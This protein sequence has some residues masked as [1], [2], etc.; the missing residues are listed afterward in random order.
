MLARY[1]NAPLLLLLWQVAPV[2][3]RRD[4]EGRVRVSFGYGR[5]T[6]SFRDIA[7][8]P[9][10]ADCN[11]D[12][13]PATPAYT[14]DQ[15]YSSVGAAGEVWANP[16]IRINAAAGGVKDDSWV[17]GGAFFALQP[18]WE[19][20]NYGLGFGLAYVGG[21]DAILRPSASARLGPID[22]LS[23]RADYYQPGVAMA[24]LNGP[25]IGVGW[26]QGRSSKARVLVGLGQTPVPDS[27][28]RVGGFV[29]VGIPLGFMNGGVSF[30]GFLSGSYHGVETR[31]IYSAGIGVWFLP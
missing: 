28:R 26:N 31:R 2:Q 11:G 9:A 4:D 27:A 3:T 19:R 24:M 12:Y 5:G 15:W 6:Y 21:P 22:R 10:G 20:Q 1:L 7:A 13:V 16:H 14:E 8:A 30:S 17:S 18:A 23:V 29:E 25:R